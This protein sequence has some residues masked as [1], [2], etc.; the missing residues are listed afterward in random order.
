MPEKHILQFHN[1]TLTSATGFQKLAHVNVDNFEASLHQKFLSFWTSIRQHYCITAR[2]RI[3]RE[4]QCVCFW[5]SNQF[6]FLKKE[7]AF[8]ISNKFEQSQSLKPKH[9][10]PRKL[11]LLMINKI[12]LWQQNLTAEIQEISFSCCQ[13]K[14]PKSFF[15]VQKLI[16]NQ[17]VALQRASALHLGTDSMHSQSFNQF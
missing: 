6:D 14:Q 8:Q 12:A 7:V 16:T 2:D 11:D 13:T 10:T 5:N 4:F 9:L 3:A 15:Q 1:Q 17:S